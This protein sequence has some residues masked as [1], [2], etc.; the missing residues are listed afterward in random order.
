MGSL[1]HSSLEFASSSPT[2]LKTLTHRDPSSSFPANSLLFPHAS[3]EFGTPA[4]SSGA[5]S[6]KMFPLDPQTKAT[7]SKPRNHSLS[8]HFSLLPPF[9]SSGLT[10]FASAEPTPTLLNLKSNSRRTRTAHSDS[11]SQK[12][13]KSQ[14]SAKRMMR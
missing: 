12:S 9:P 13:Q 1:C 6:T 11:R 5:T 3:L 4:T 2:M 10:S 14:E 8:G 7:T